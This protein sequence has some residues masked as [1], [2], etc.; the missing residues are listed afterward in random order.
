[1]AD[2]LENQIRRIAEPHPIFHIHRLQINVLRPQTSVPVLI[3][4][5][6]ML[7]SGKR[8]K[9]VPVAARGIKFIAPRRITAA[10]ECNLANGF[11]VMPARN[12]IDNAADG[13]VAV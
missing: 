5:L 2:I 11:I 1:M 7:Q 12:N 3:I 4:P 10:G 8:P 13:V 6:R 9:R